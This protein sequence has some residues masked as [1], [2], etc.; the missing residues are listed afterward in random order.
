MFWVTAVVSDI[1]FFKSGLAKTILNI[2]KINVYGKTRCVSIFVCGI[3]GGSG[4]CCSMS[5]RSPRSA[6]GPPITVTLAGVK[7]HCKVPVSPGQGCHALPAASCLPLSP[8]WAVIAHDAV[9][10]FP[11]LGTLHLMYRVCRSSVFKVLRG[12][13]GSKKS[14]HL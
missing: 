8:L 9:R 7:Y 4:L 12:T 14:S 2:I 13:R 3:P 1:E 5:S 11:L 10:P 6:R